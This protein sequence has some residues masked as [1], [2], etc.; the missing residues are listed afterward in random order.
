MKNGQI[1]LQ[2]LIM[3]SI[4]T[5]LI[6]GFVFW[7]STY[8]H[9]VTRATNNAQAFTIA[10][11]GIEYY[12]WHLAH[13]PLDFTDGQS[14]TSTGPYVHQYFDKNGNDI[15]Q[16]DLVITKPATGTTILAI[17]S[18]G[19]V[20][21]DPTVSK[22]IKVQM[23]LPS[24]ARYSVAAN[25]DM[26]FGQGTN[27]YGQVHSNGGVH[28]DG[29]AYNIVTSAKTTYNDPDYSESDVFGVYTRVS[30]QDP[31]PPATVPVRSDVFKAGRQFPVPAV[32]F[33][34]ITQNLAD[35]K[36][37]ATS[38]SGYYRGPS[39]SKGYD[40]V[41]K[42]NDTF[43][44]YKVTGITNLST[45]CKN[46]SVQEAGWG[47]WSISAETLISSNVPF[48]A[49]G[50]I[51]IEDDLWVRGQISTARLNIGAG[52]FPVNA[53]T[54]ANITLNKSLTY[55]NHDGQDVL[56]L[57]SQ[58]NLNVGLT[59][60]NVLPIE[61]A[62]I[63]QNGRVGRYHYASQCGSNYTRSTI[64]LYGMLATNKRYG[65][66]W[67][68]GTGYTTR[69]ITYDANL[70]YGPPP[71]FPITASQYDIISWDEVK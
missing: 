27:I 70:L 52:R 5:F 28:F 32:D 13:A 14:A 12:R 8:M 11:A 33:N 46:N 53:S 60:D 69:N 44:I 2:V 66:A 56:G 15:G 7:T 25:A 67:T 29:V 71:G 54:Y 22:I 65:F 39:G 43:D 36:T 6:M 50:I 23:G 37:A 51:F 58:N 26:R 59:S 9:G 35:M 45:T 68:D 10:E 17:Q 40:I 38:S 57:I 24:F 20:D 4:G 55:T 49:N 18:T 42:T 16:F 62:L 21:Y 64:S 34:G 47:S 3:G 19:K 61:A 31:F 63:A 30:P 41:L 1:S 48:P